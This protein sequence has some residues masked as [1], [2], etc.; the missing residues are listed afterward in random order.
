MIRGGMSID[1][2]ASNVRVMIYD[3]SVRSPIASHNFELEGSI[4]PLSA[5]TLLAELVNKWE[6]Q[7][8]VD[9]TGIVV[10]LAAL[11]DQKGTIISW[12][13]RPDWNGFP[14]KEELGRVIG[15]PIALFD[16]AHLAALGEYFFSLG[17]SVENL[18]YVTV[19]TGIGSAVVLGGQLYKGSRGASGQLG[20]ITVHLSGEPCPCG[21]RGCL[22]LYASGRGI[23]RQARNLGLAINK[24]SEVFQL[25]EEGNEIALNLLQDS[26]R[27]LAIGIANAVRMFDPTVVI[28]GGG[29]VKRFPYYYRA[30][31]H[32][33][34]TFLG[35]F[36]Q[37]DVKVN[38]STLSDQAALWG[39]LAYGLQ[40]F[41]GKE[42]RSPT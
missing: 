9:I 20:H 1:F 38:L 23:E 29:M 26:M 41:N 4:N 3:F 10:G 30:L 13:N 34:Q 36:P 32:N 31:E 27:T 39:G 15:K 17:R 25:A 6:S 40:H 35:T 24:A 33:V 42:E 2:G 37:K 28:V 18:L 19:G 7:F 16:D 11:H 14:F 5:F 12:P 22:Q 21:G 8:G